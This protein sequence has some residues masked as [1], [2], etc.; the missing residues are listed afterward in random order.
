M[1]G[2]PSQ[3]AW[4]ERLVAGLAAAGHAQKV[5][6]DA[7]LGRIERRES[8]A[9]RRTPGFDQARVLRVNGVGIERQ[10][11]AAVQ[12]GQKRRQRLRIESEFELAGL[13]HVSRP[14]H[15]HQAIRVH[16]HQRLVFHDA[17]HLMS[18]RQCDHRLLRLARSDEQ[19]RLSV[20]NVGR[21][22]RQLVHQ[23]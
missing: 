6:V 15:A 23:R 8:L 18:A 14:V 5:E 17:D 1:S 2:L 13:D 10:Q 7:R 20:Y 4:A 9:R 21:Q 3:T 11:S 12:L 19:R 22:R 16:A